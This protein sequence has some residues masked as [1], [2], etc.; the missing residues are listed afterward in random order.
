MTDPT[1]RFSDRVDAYAAYRPAY[2]DAAADAVV[3]GIGPGCPAADIGAGTG[4]SSVMLARRGVPVH[5]VEP[6]APMREHGERYTASLADA[7]MAAI[8]WHAATGEHT[9][10]PSGSVSLVLCAQSFHWLDPA[11]ALTEFRRILVPGGRVALVWNVH[12]TR[13]AMMADY[14]A[15]V[16][17]HAVDPPRSPWFSNSDCALGSDT[18][19]SLGLVDFRRLEFENSQTVDLAGLIGRA[20]SSS[21]M[22]RAGDARAAVEA[23]LTLLFNRYASADGAWGTPVVSLKYVCEVYMAESTRTNRGNP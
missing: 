23:E 12:D 17:R 14:R 21:Y 3:R 1:E 13:D 20:V 18:G 5:A 9:G 4:I 10:L 7:S 11:A 2:P 16:M 6:N 22:P 19:R 8:R 15:L